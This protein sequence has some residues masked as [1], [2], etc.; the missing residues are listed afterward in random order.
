MQQM[1]R[2]LDSLVV[3]LPWVY[4][5]WWGFIGACIGSFLNVVIYRM[6]QGLSLIHPGSCCPKCK[7]KIRGFDNVPVISWLILRGKCRECGYPFR[8]VT[9][10]WKRST[11][12]CFCVLPWPWCK[13]PWCMEPWFKLAQQIVSYLGVAALRC[14]YYSLGFSSLFAM[15]AIDQDRFSIPLKL[16]LVG[17]SVALLCILQ[18]TLPLQGWWRSPVAVPE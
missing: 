16:F 13:R 3:D 4:V 15:V 9:R 1:Q 14:G 10:S 11:V 18:P 2:T 12:S 17:L 8:S 5:L 6:P 7:R